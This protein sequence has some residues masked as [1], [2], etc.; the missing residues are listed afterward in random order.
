[1]GNVRKIRRALAR[2][3]DFLLP[4]DLAFRKDISFGRSAASLATW[5]LIIGVAY[6]AGHLWKS[7]NVVVAE[8][9]MPTADAKPLYDRVADG[10]VVILS[11]LA[12]DY[13]SPALTSLEISE[14]VRLQKRVEKLEAELSTLREAQP[15]PERLRGRPRRSDGAVQ[16]AALEVTS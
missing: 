1:M 6:G 16:V 7:S 11:D 9:P 3:F 12:C 10:N 14:I 4:K 8:T 2:F 13:P 5:A 15:K